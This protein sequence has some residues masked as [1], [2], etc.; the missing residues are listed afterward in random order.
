[1]LVGAEIQ[2]S[3]DPNIPPSPATRLLAKVQPRIL[4]AANDAR[5]LAEMSDLPGTP[6]IEQLRRFA[7]ENPPPQEWFDG[8]EEDLFTPDPDT[9]TRA[10]SDFEAGRSRP[11]R[12]WI[13]E[14]R[15]KT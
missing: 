9:M 15:K 4:V 8:E 11:V 6:S 10:M 14:L 7:A 12:E 1:M 5:M 2:R 13:D 3:S